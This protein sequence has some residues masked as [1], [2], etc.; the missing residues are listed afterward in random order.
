M[1]L[2][3]EI[4]LQVDLVLGVHLEEIKTYS[5]NYAYKLA[6][7]I[8]LYMSLLEKNLKYLVK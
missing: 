2:G 5:S 8:H 7:C 3:R 1:M 6:E 4:T